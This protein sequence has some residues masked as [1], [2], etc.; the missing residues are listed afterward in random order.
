M[1][2]KESILSKCKDLLQ[3]LEPTQES[4]VLVTNYFFYL[5]NK[6]FAQEI[7]KLWE[8]MFA[9]SSPCQK[10][11]LIYLVNHIIQCE[12]RDGGK[13]KVLFKKTIT[14]SIEKAYKLASDITIRERII[15]VVKL[16]K[17]RCIFDHTF[18]RQI[19]DN[20][21]LLETK[22][23]RISKHTGVTL[24]YEKV[25]PPK[26][27]VELAENL[28]KADEWLVNVKLMQ[29]TLITILE[30]KEIDYCEVELRRKQVE[31][32]QAVKEMKHY[33]AT[34]QEI[35]AKLT[36][37]EDNLHLQEAL[38][39]RKVLDSLIKVKWVRRGGNN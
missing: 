18:I 16:W 30:G 27:L 22:V 20:L 13:L 11:S 17:E 32:E 8:T 7:F 14:K 6:G 39:I 21:N 26:L 5:S 1:L 3:K 33:S 29:S 4:I 25:N 23:Q 36:K 24:Q 12:Y 2:K 37:S 10:L 38:Q 9:I 19:L 31:Y 15:E 28:A 34:V 35:L